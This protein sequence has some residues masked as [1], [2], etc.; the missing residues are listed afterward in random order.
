[1]QFN[2]LVGAACKTDM[3]EGNVSFTYGTLR[4]LS[5]YNS[6]SVATLSGSDI[7]VVEFDLGQ[8]IHLDRFEYKFSDLM[9]TTANV[10]SGISFFYK[11]EN[12]ESYIQLP[13]I[14]HSDW[15]FYTTLS[16]SYTF[17]PRY[18]KCTHTLSGTY[19]APTTSGTLYGFKAFN[20]DTIVN[21]GTTA[22][23]ESEVV[24][25]ARTVAADIRP[26]AI[27]NSGSSIANAVVNIEP[28]FYSVDEVLS[29]S[30]NIDGPWIKPLDEGDIKVNSDNIARGTLY[31]S[32]L[33]DSTVVINGAFVTGGSYVTGYDYGLYTTPVIKRGEAMYSRIVLNRDINAPG[34]IAVDRDDSVE[35]IEFRS[36]NAPPKPYAIIRTLANGNDQLVYKD[37]FLDTL[38]STPNTYT[39]FGTSIGNY[40]WWRNYGI[41]HDKTTDR[42]VCWAH[43]RS[44]DYRA[45][46]VL[47]ILSNKG[48]T[49]ISKDLVQCGGT[50]ELNFDF[51]FMEIDYSG[52]MWIYFHSQSY[53]T[54]QFVDAT[55]YY[56]AYF[57]S[58]LNNTF[59]WFLSTNEIGAMD[60]NY[61]TRELWYTRPS[62]SAIY[63]IGIDGTVLAEFADAEYTN[64]LG[65]VVVLPNGDLLFSNGKYIHYLNYNGYLFEEA[66]ILSEAENRIDFVALDGDGSEAVWVIDNLF[67]GRL[68][69]S[70]PDKGTF[71]FKVGNIGFPI[72]IVSVTGGAWVRCS[73]SGTDSVVAMKFISKENRRVDSTFYPSYS[74][75]PVLIYDAYT[76]SKYNDRLPIASD[77]YWTYLPWNKVATD[78]FMLPEDA[79]YQIRVTLR[80]RD[81]Y[82][83]WPDLTTDRYQ[84]PI[85]EDYF[86]QSSIVPNQLIWG[87]WSDKPLTNR[88]SV[89]S[90]GTL[91]LPSGYASDSF[92]DT[93]NRVVYGVG[94]NNQL[95][96]A[97]GYIIANGNGVLSNKAEKLH[98]YLDSVD[99]GFESRY[100]YC[101]LDMPINPLT[102]NTY[103][104][105][106][107]HDLNTYT[108]FTAG[109][110]F[111][112][113]E[114][115]IK[116]DF[117]NSTFSSSVWRLNATSPIDDC[118]YTNTS[119]NAGSRFKFRV[120]SAKDGSNIQLKYVRV[121]SGRAYHY[122][123]TPNITGIY[124]QK[125]LEVNNIYPNSYKNIYMKTFVP[126]DLLIESGHEVDIKTRWRV[127]SY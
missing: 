93:T 87:N 122:I 120:A 83:A 89:T 24:E 32:K 125:L 6:T 84:L 53:A 105:I 71:D 88:V 19:G 52:G 46:S 66:S 112:E 65:S 49:S 107:R 54:G 51:K 25:V 61:N 69:V 42:H 56:L 116:V 124:E 127:A 47:Y 16:G 100:I 96:I 104:Y 35:T 111:Y 3:M 10:A 113:A 28:K 80:R 108:Y 60:I 91:T 74:S 126:R 41:V 31:G 39:S 102:T 43:L 21:F 2:V 26:I 109:L 82:E 86:D 45:N 15:L 58:S 101:R 11:D 85:K 13:T 92:I 33:R 79:Y 75:T 12:F 99:V 9:S 72:S 57:D 77:N 27:Y 117:S 20:N 68:F 23:K 59:K 119:A 73:E 36:S 62:S 97:V 78:T 8:R 4:E 98:L 64:D 76:D 95:E 22:A 38:V 121:I 5:D 110:N 115:R 106:G 103:I 7:L 40:R 44:G 37:Y 18:L 67:V 34:R 94:D 50:I 1:M 14:V 48:N 123:D 114:I 30:Q 70:G 118:D 55:G 90:S 81:L 17:A 29:I 63:K